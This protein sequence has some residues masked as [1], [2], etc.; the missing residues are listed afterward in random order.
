MILLPVAWLL[1]IMVS[2][3]VGSYIAGQKMDQ[4]YSD[5]QTR[6][7]LDL[8]MKNHGFA[9]S[10][11]TEEYKLQ[12]QKLSRQDKTEYRNILST[13]VKGEDM[14]SFGS[15]FVIG[16]IVFGIIG[17]LSGILTTMWIPAGIFPILVLSLENPLRHFTFLGYMT[18]NQKVITVLI[19]QFMTC[20]AFAYFGALISKRFSRKK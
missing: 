8:F 4:A 12:Y 1:S 20:Y 17:I 6:N 9:E 7:A 18:T 10:M 13:S 16:V 15:V 14:F 19:S 5:P 11:T 3:F 2:G